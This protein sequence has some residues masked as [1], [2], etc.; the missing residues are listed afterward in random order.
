MIV[1]VSRRCDI[2]RFQFDWFMEQLNVGFVDVANPFNAA[3]VR[4]VPL[5][6]GSGSDAAEVLVFWT[7]DPRAILACTEELERWGFRYYVMVTVTGYPAVLEPN[8]LPTETVCADMGCLAQKIGRQRVIWRYDPIFLS[9]ITDKDFHRRNF[10]AL[11]QRLT[12]STRR[13]IISLYDEYRGAKRRIEALERAGVLRIP[14]AVDGERRPTGEGL[15]AGGKAPS[16][17][18]TEPGIAALLTDMAAIANAAGMEIQSCAE[19]ENFEPMGIKAGACIDGELI[20]ELWGI[21]IAGKD[22]HQR[23]HCLCAQ[24][25][26]IGRYGDCQAGCVYCYAR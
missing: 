9:S 25:V 17:R 7:R 13:V 14:L 11:A 10:S 26:D 24:S 4:R 6:P 1:S 22:K 15:S 23:P 20:K 21:E 2:P 8:V 5:Q 12:S 18:A 3:Q 16:P 19:T